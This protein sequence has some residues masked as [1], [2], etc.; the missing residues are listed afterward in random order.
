MMVLPR[1]GFFLFLAAA[2]AAGPA[3]AQGNRP[4]ARSPAAGDVAGARDYPGLPRFE[5]SSLIGYQAL[6]FDGFRLPTGPARQNAQFNWE[7][8]DALE[9]EGKVS[10]YVY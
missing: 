1:L 7:I 6:P 8:P 10:G 4:A 5:G 2:A 3:L 9:I